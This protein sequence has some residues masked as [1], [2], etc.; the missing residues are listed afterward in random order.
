MPTK[1]VVRF[2]IYTYQALHCRKVRISI[3]YAY[4]RLM[5]SVDEPNKQASSTWFF[6]PK[7]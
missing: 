6:L 4:E 7:T 3:G 5:D 2:K 1:S